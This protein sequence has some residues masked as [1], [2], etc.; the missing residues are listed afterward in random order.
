[1]QLSVRPGIYSLPSYSLTGDLVGFLRCGLQ[2]RYTRIGKL[3]S[4]QPIQLWFGEFIH[5]VLEEAFRRYDESLRNKIPNLPPWPGDELEEIIDLIMRRLAARQLFPWSQVLEKQ[6]KAR[7]K[8][9]VNELGPELFPLIHR[10]EV[11]LKGARVL[12]THK[13]PASYRIRN[14]DRYEMVG[15][16]DVVTH[17]E[18]NN[19]AHQF[20]RLLNAIRGQLPRSL[21]E[22]FE[23]IIDYKGMRRPPVKVGKGETSYWDV[24]GWQIQ[25]YAHLRR[26]QSDSLPVVAGIILYVNELQPSIDD[27]LTMLT[28]I[29]AGTTDIRPE[30]KSLFF[31][32]LQQWLKAY[33]KSSRAHLPGIPFDFRLKRALRLVS[34]N[35]AT[36]EKSLE[37]FDRVVV[38]IE[39]CRGKE[40]LSG[41]VL[42]T[43]VKNASDENTCKACDSRT[44]C[45]AYKSEKYPSLPAIK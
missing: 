20:N 36:I 26:R 6:G 13:I 32:E 25:T 33:Q 3:P 29:E 23:V 2:Y 11:R 43:W 31:R 30:A 42:K 15:V 17:V 5:G 4:S 12:P 10:A 44:Y 35:D 41:S 27:V 40:M 18:L 9:A 7:A 21:P 34:V 37:A 8:I 19:R 16:V 45:D 22:R 38:Q 24:Y 14:A 1:M 28:E 39:T